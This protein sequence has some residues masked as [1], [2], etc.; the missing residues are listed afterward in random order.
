M[1]EKVKV[2][3]IDALRADDS[4]YQ[5]SAA[6]YPARGR[7]PAPGPIDWSREIQLD[8]ASDEQL[9]AR[10]IALQNA[11]PERAGIADYAIL[12]VAGGFSLVIAGLGLWKAA[13]LMIAVLR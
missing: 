7:A 13:E 2:R 1:N 11:A 3:T 4:R 6:G 12:A 9:R 10:V 8:V 5:E